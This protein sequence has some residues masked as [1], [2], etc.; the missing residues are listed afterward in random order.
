MQIPQEELASNILL[1]EDSQDRPEVSGLRHPF[2]ESSLGTANLL[3]LGSDESRGRTAHQRVDVEAPNRT[4]T[5]TPS[6]V[7]QYGGVMKSFGGEADRMPSFAPVPKSSSLPPD[8]APPSSPN[9][10]SYPSAPPLWRG[11]NAQSPAYFMNAGQVPS[12]PSTSSQKEV[13][14]PMQCLDR[15]VPRFWFVVSLATHFLSS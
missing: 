11:L 2:F 9:F 1:D 4:P 13:S 15:Q 12:A 7:Y 10:P 6:P 14:K 8:S 3:G 5:R